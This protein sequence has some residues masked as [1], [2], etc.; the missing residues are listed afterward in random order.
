[1]RTAAL[2]LFACV[3]LPGLFCCS[4]NDKNDPVTVAQECY[5][6]LLAGNYDAFL[7]GRAHMDS[8]PESFREQLLV[9]YKQFV[10]DQKKSHGGISAFKAMSAQTDSANHQSLVF[11]Q[12]IFADSTTEEIVVPMVECNGKWKMR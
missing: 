1:M 8:I 5:D 10:F 6:M 11:M 4:S 9:N 2:W 7:A 3:T 12:V